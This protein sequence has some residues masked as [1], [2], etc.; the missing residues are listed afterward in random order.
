MLIVQLVPVL[1]LLPVLLAGLP[2]EKNKCKNKASRPSIYILESI[3]I[4][5]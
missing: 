1:T 2:R 5:N 3:K 4:H